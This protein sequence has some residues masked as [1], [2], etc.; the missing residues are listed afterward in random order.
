MDNIKVSVVIPVY[1]TEDY[2]NDAIKSILDQTLVDIEIIVIND[3]STDRSL[4]IISKLANLDG[5][6]R[7]VNRE[8]KGISN[9]RNE[10]ISKARGKYIYFMDSDDVL[11]PNALCECLDR[12]ENEN[13][14][15]VF[16]NAEAFG[17]SSDLSLFTYFQRTGYVDGATR[18]GLDMLKLLN[19]SGNLQISACLNFINLSFLKRIELCFYPNILYEDELFVY[20]LYLKAERVSYLSQRFYRRR[21]R[22]ESIMTGKFSFA[23]INSYFVIESE[24]IRLMEE[25]D[26]GEVKIMISKR[27]HEI[28]VS[29]LR[30]ARKGTARIK[31]LVFRHCIIKLRPFLLPKDFKLLFSLILSIAV[32][33]LR[34][35]KA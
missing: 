8:N 5:R 31:L 27:L 12:C 22:N 34:G 15:F 18:S 1:N 19:S 21:V 35:K 6:I 26:S 3:G 32:S 7:I 30:K 16:F 20:Q 24:L 23:N 28:I 10:G 9:S 33:V 11:S 14:D 17:E 29:M 25:T 13:L 4:S 2:V